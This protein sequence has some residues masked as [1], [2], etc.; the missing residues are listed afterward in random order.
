MALGWLHTVFQ[1]SQ[2]PLFIK[3][4]GRGQ[5]QKGKIKE[6]PERKGSES[7]TYLNKAIGMKKTCILK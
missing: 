4:E 1:S 3:Q 6:E 5:E 2:N 7:K